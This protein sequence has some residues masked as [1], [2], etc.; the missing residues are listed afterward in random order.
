MVSHSHRG[1][2]GYH[3][4]TPLSREDGGV[5]LVN[6]GWVPSDNKDPAT[7]ADGQVA[8]S[9]VVDGIARKG[10][11]QASFVPDNDPVKNVW[12]FADLPAIAKTMNID[13]PTVYVAAGAAPNPG[14]YPLGGQTRGT[15]RNNHLAYAITWYGLAVALVA[16]YILWHR[17]RRKRAVA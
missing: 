1:N 9:V 13:P 7:R 5:V 17:S 10:W 8:G 11:G 6:R 16:I 4:Y 15:L 3:I 14:G 2:L 12:F